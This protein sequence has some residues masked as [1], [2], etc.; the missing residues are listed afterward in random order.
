MKRIYEIVLSAG[1][2]PFAKKKVIAKDFSEAYLKALEYR[3]AEMDHEEDMVLEIDRI[4]Y[5][6]EIDESN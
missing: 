6:C 2:Y 3:E 4:V 1:D 5:D